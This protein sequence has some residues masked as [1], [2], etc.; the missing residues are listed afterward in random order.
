MTQEVKAVRRRQNTTGVEL[1]I[2]KDT[3]LTPFCLKAGSYWRQVC[4]RNNGSWY[5]RTKDGEITLPED[6]IMVLNSLAVRN[7][8]SGRLVGRLGR[9]Q[10]LGGKRLLEARIEAQA[11]IEHRSA[12]L[13]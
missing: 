4:V 3:A 7:A 13:C 8:D 1:G 6:L 10:A 5:I 9:N 12:V 2:Y 11:V